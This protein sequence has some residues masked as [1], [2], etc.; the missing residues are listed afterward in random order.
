MK[1]YLDLLQDIIDNGY[2]TPDR[3]GVGRRHVFGRQMRFKMT[4]GFPLVTTRKVPIKNAI[5]EML[6][7]LKGDNS[8]EFLKEN[9]CN[10]WDLWTVKPTDVAAFINE[11]YFKEEVTFDSDEFATQW[12]ELHSC[13]DALGAAGTV[14]NIYG[15]NW[16]CIETPDKFLEI[17][18]KPVSTDIIASDRKEHFNI[19]YEQYKAQGNE[20]VSEEEFAALFSRKFHDQF[21]ELIFNLKQKPY[22]ARHIV[23]A[24]VPYLVANEHNSPEVNVLEGRGAL[25]PCHILQQYLVKPPKEEGGKKR[26]SLMLTMR[27]C[28]T[29]VGTPTNVAQY[30]LL[31]MMVAQCTDMEADEFI[32]S[33]GDAHIYLDQIDLAKEQIKREPRALPTMWIN[34]EVKDIFSFK[35][36]DFELKDYNPDEPIKYPLAK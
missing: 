1:Q 12:L 5:I 6:W 23:S 8:V 18:L 4:D 7:F 17:N 24:W 29:P 15:P 10:I 19:S 27:S 2:D 11:R 9:N 26:L 36:T 16:R 25:A 34:P 32:I 33:M 35:P 14:G 31:L 13:S 22:S 30:S 28:D 21:A 3:T 20:E